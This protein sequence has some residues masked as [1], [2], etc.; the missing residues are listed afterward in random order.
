[1][2]GLDAMRECDA[3][4]RTLVAVTDSGVGIKEANLE[5]VCHAFYTTKPITL[6]II[7]EA[8]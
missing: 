7:K 3:G 2:N 6:P 8:A 1:M 4:E 5:Q